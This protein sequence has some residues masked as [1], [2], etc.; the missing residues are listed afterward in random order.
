MNSLNCMLSRYIHLYIPCVNT[1]YV[2][3]WGKGREMA[4]MLLDIV[5]YHQ[6]SSHRHAGP[7]GPFHCFKE[8]RGG[9]G[10]KNNMKMYYKIQ[11]FFHLLMF[12]KGKTFF[13]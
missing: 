4:L 3:L 6:H 2:D 12:G 1:K 9:G 7:I 10:K 5:Y 11:T 8:I 13:Y